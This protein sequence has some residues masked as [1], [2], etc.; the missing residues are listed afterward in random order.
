[1]K[2]S[3]DILILGGGPIGASTAYHLSRQ[4]KKSIG[5]ITAEPAEAA[6]AT[7]QSAGGCIRWFWDEA[8]KIDMTKTTADFIIDLARSG[9]DVSLREDTYLFL[10]RGV[11]VPAINVSGVKVVEHFLSEA[12]AHGVSVHKNETVTEVRRSGSGYEVVTD[13]GSYSATKVLLALGA[14]NV[15]FMPDYELEEEKRYLL[16]LDLPVKDAERMFPHTIA[17]IGNGYAFVFVKK[18]PEGWRFLI[19]EEDI[20]GI[21]TSKNLTAHYKKLLETGVAEIMPFLVKARVERMLSGTDVENKT[22]LLK[23]KKGLY[24]AN[25][26]SA[27]RSCVWIGQQVAE[28]IAA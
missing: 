9:V 10:D 8:K 18:L 17:K 6:Y 23:G 5:L 2:N 16:V 3:Y 15:R 11:H 25:C 19:G 20:L 14:Q 1:M 27:V 4:G 22:L 26:G 13:K 7:Y 24:A 28:R 21:P 12:S